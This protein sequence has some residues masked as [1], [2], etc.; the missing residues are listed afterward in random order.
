[1]YTIQNYEIEADNRDSLKEFLS[2]NGIGTLIQ[3]GGKGIH[4]FKKLG[5]DISLPF[6]EKVF[7]KME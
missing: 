5:F 7:E 2:Q 6:S 4:Q 3:W 1:M